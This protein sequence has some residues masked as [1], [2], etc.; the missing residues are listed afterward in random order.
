MARYIDVHTDVRGLTA[1]D[2][3]RAHRRNLDLRRSRGVDRGEY[4]YDEATPKLFGLVQAP[5]SAAAIAVHRTILRLTAE[6][7]VEVQAGR[8]R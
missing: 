1:E 2:L 8:T 7:I 4:W 3:A 5:G 6:E